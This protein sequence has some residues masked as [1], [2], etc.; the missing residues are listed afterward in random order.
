MTI[1]GYNTSKDSTAHWRTE[2]AC[3]S[4]KQKSQHCQK[5]QSYRCTEQGQIGMIAPTTTLTPHKVLQ[6]QDTQETTGSSTQKANLS[7]HTD[8]TGR[9]SSHHQEHSVQP[10]QLEDYRRTAVRFKD[11]TTNTFEDKCQTMEELNK[12]QQQ[13]WKGET[14]FRI[15]KGTTLPE[16]LQQQFATKTQ[17]QKVTPQVIQHNPRTRL[18]EK[19]TPPT[20]RRSWTWTT[21]SF[22]STSWRRLLVQRR[23]TLEE[24]TRRASNSVLHTRADTRRARHQATHT[25]ERDQGTTSWRKTQHK[26]GRRCNTTGAQRDTPSLQELVSNIRTSKRHSAQKNHAKQ[27]SKFPTI[28]L[29]FGCITGFDDSNVHPILTAIDIQSGMIVAMQLTVTTGC[30]STTQS[31]SYSASSL[32]VEEQH[33]PYHNQIRKTS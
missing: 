29:D 30:F 24:G 8:N 26:I 20:I 31:H 6:I 32:N 2:M 5:E 3:S 13:M 19:T 11:G 7:E 27:R 12:A 18:R 33:T 23:P 14:A 25:L 17:P 10:Q 28:Q 21:T 15:R 4:Y 22:R 9:H 1:Q 16:T